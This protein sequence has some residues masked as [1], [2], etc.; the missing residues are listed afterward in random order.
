[1]GNADDRLER[2]DKQFS[3]LSESLHERLDGIEKQLEKPA[4]KEREPWNRLKVFS[5]IISGVLVA[6]IGLWATHSITGAIERQRLELSH[7]T[8]MRE[9]MIKLGDPKVE[10]SEAE[11]TGVLL[12]AF[13]SRAV[14]PLIHELGKPGG[15]RPL[16]ARAGLRAAAFKDPDGTCELLVQVLE[17]RRGLFSWRTQE[18]AVRLIG[19]IGCLEA[20]HVLREYR[21]LLSTDEGRK[22]YVNMVRDEPRPN[23]KAMGLLE[24]Q[25]KIA[26]EKL[27]Q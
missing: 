24:K 25:V 17:N 3:E 9:L 15:N 26:L 20:A 13:G 10:R 27:E 21:D 7:L 22:K 18:E 1:M 14:A 19:E 23:V 12:G 6:L 16:A 5:P 8:A 4:S 2:L 11:A